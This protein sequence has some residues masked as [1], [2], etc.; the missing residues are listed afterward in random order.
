[1]LGSVVLRYLDGVDD[2][3]VNN[4]R[5]LLNESLAPDPALSDDSVTTLQ[6]LCQEVGGSFHDRLCT[7]VFCA[8]MSVLW[9]IR[10]LDEAA[11]RARNSLRNAPRGDAPAK[12]CA[13]DPPEF[14]RNHPH[15]QVQTVRVSHDNDDEYLDR[16]NK[17][18]RVL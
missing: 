11:Q 1:M 7:P 5:I 17:R 13:I 4:I 18:Q 16:M 10:A 15:A 12:G 2:S 3:L 9:M 8:A 14:T 6:L